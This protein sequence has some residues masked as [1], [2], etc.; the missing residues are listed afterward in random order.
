VRDVNWN[1]FYETVEK[2]LEEE[3]YASAGKSLS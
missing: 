2:I 1:E 3:K